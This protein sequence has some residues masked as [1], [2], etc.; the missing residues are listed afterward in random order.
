MNLLVGTIND[1]AESDEV[2]C[3]IPGNGH[4]ACRRLSGGA[5]GGGGG[6]DDGGVLVMKPAYTDWAA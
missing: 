4:A 2:C 3:S 1:E 5:G 6:G